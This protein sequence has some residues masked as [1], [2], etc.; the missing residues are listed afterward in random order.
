MGQTY[1][2][3]HGQSDEYNR[4]PPHVFSLPQLPTNTFAHKFRVR[5]IY[6]HSQNGEEKRRFRV[7]NGGTCRR[8]GSR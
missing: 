3:K 5:L 6:F 1:G 7:G 2:G 4:D 8:T